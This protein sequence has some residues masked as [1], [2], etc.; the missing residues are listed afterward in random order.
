MASRMGLNLEIFEIVSLEKGSSVGSS[1]RTGSTSGPSRLSKKSS[2]L[3]GLG[4]ESGAAGCCCEA[5][6]KTEGIDE[7]EGDSAPDLS[8]LGGEASSFGFFVGG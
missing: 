5:G 3:T 1:F 8:C 2:V 6:R 4:C 7:Q